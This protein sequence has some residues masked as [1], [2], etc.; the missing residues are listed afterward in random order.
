MEEGYLVF[1]IGFEVKAIQSV[2]RSR[3]SGFARG[4]Q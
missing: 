1:E 2:S 4:G 3:T